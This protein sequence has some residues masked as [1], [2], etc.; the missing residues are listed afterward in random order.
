M[1]RSAWCSWDKA[2]AAD[3]MAD[4]A[5]GEDARCATM[6][7]YRA[8]QRWASL[9]ASSRSERS[10]SDRSRRAATSAWA[11]WEAT[12]AVSARRSAS[13]ICISRSFSAASSRERRADASSWEAEP[14]LLDAAASPSSLA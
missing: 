9:L 8:S 11:T 3:G 5:A 10:A 4:R 13:S 14:P 2:S 6:S 12:R 1:D 7:L